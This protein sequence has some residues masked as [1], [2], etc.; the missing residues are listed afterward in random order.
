MRRVAPWIIVFAAVAG[1]AAGVV[2]L[3]EAGKG[4]KAKVKAATKTG[5]IAGTVTF[6][7]KPPKPA[8][9]DIT[10]PVCARA[11]IADETVVVDAR[12]GVK[13]AFVSLSGKGLASKPP[14][15]PVVI[16]QRGCM[17]RPRVTGV[18]RGQSVQ[19]EN[20]DSTLHNIHAYVGGATEFNLA[21][22]KGAKPIEKTIEEGNVL[23]LKCDVHPWMRAYAVH[24]DNAHFAVTAD[25]GSFEITGVPAGTYTLTA[26]HPVLGETTA[27]VKVLKGKTTKVA[28]TLTK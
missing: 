25:S 13:D 16:D 9:L 23:E 1:S 15:E 28:A 19:I 24:V 3:A 20:A 21:Q 26:W 27:Q 7:G 11:G 5:A 18:V 17:Y 12:G 14:S 6:D 2:H 8:K 22:P 10:D 4:G